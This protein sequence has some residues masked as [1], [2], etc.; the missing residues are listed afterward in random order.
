MTFY[1]VFLNDVLGISSNLADALNILSFYPD[2]LVA[3]NGLSI[4]DALHL[5]KEEIPQYV[6]NM[7]ISRCFYFLPLVNRVI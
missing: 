2:N 5:E 6:Q 7:E 4:L 3:Y 1:S